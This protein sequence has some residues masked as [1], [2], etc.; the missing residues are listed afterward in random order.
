[1]L[2]Y[3]V[4][5]GILIPQLNIQKELQKLSNKLL[6]NLIM[7]ELSFQ[8]KKKIL[9]RLKWWRMFALMCLLMKISWFFQ[10]L[11]QIKTLKTRWIYCC[12]KMII[13]F[14]MCTS[15]ILTDLCFTKQK[16]KIKSTFVE[17]VYSVLLVKIFWQNIEKIA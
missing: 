2:F 5:L 11:L 7:I 9:I 12:L 16:I 15:N 8:W 17:A 3:G 13:I 6:N 10:C 14:I 4:M 1:M